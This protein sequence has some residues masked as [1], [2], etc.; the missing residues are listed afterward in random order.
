MHVVGFGN[1]DEDFELVVLGF[2]LE[3]IAKGGPAAV[4]DLLD[5]RVDPEEEEFIVCEFVCA[6]ELSLESCSVCTVEDG[7]HFDA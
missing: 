4:L 5:D 6:R 2:A 3:A 7:L 1:P